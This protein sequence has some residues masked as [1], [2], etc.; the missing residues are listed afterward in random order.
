MKGTLKSPLQAFCLG[1]L[2]WQSDKSARWS[3]NDISSW[4][5]VCEW[6]RHLGWRG[7]KN[8]RY[9]VF[10]VENWQSRMEAENW[11][12]KRTWTATSHLSSGHKVD[13][14]GLQGGKMVP[15]LCA[16]FHH[17]QQT[18]NWFGL[19][20]IWRPDPD[21]FGLFV[22]FLKPLLHLTVGPVGTVIM[23]E[24]LQE[25]MWCTIMFR[26]VGCVL[27]REKSHFPNTVDFFIMP[28]I[29]PMLKPS[30]NRI[31]KCLLKTNLN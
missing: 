22:K 9:E 11:N 20:G 12:I 29:L 25:C 30:L 1:H 21:S 7:P 24:L 16:W 18:L 8:Y 26:W 27:C 17:I 23:A 13:P 3:W 19:L 6:L 31:I 2:T 15:L 14:L 28:E 10:P 5:T 4:P